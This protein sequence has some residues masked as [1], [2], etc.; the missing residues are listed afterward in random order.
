MRSAS[1]TIPAAREFEMILT[2][3][4]ISAEPVEQLVEWQINVSRDGGQT[5]E[6]L[7]GGDVWG[8]GGVVPKFSPPKI[9]VTIHGLDGYLASGYVVASKRLRF[10][11]D[12][13]IYT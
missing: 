1:V 8:T 9:A 11:V 10:G 6:H 3:L 12:G 2:G 4:D 7:A 13:E 5:W